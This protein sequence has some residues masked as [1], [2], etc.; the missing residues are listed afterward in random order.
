MLNTMIKNENTSFANIWISFLR[1]WSQERDQNVSKTC[2]FI[3][4]HS[5]QHNEAS[6]YTFYNPQCIQEINELNERLQMNKEIK[7]ILV[8]K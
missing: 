6:G 8:L 3:F 1:S 7:Y 4:H 2:V 5:F